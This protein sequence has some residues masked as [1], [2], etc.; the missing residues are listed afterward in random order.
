[1]MKHSLPGYEYVVPTAADLYDAVDAGDVL[2][3]SAGRCGKEGIEV[4]DG[5]VAV[6]YKGEWD[7]NGKQGFCIGL[8][9]ITNTVDTL[10][11]KRGS[12]Y[13]KGAR[14]LELI[15]SDDKYGEPTWLVCFPIIVVPSVAEDIGIKYRQAVELTLAGA[16]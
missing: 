2:E 9:P 1:M 7:E 3:V 5:Y 11:L 14:D 12:V 10:E 16:F 13:C 6:L 4:R 15:A 8:S